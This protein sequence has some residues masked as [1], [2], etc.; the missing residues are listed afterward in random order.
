MLVYE[1]NGGLRKK[2]GETSVVGIRKTSLER[3]QGKGEG[4]KTSGIKEIGGGYAGAFLDEGWN[5]G[6]CAE[7]PS[8][9]FGGKEGES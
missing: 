8:S 3:L 9:G 7:R 1:L 6:G 2:G 4:I 5:G